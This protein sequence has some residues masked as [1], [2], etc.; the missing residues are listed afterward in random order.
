MVPRIHRCCQPDSW[1]VVPGCKLLCTNCLPSELTETREVNSESCEG[2]CFPQMYTDPA[3]LFL[4]AQ[5]VVHWEI[6]YC[7]SCYSALQI[8]LQ[9]LLASLW[10]DHLRVSTLRLLK[11]NAWRMIPRS[12]V[13]KISLLVMA[14]PLFS[15][16]SNT[17]ANTRTSYLHLFGMRRDEMPKDHAFVCHP[18]EESTRF[19]LH[20]LVT[21]E[22]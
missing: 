2:N 15:L 8:N 5:E 9:E 17:G 12:S 3:R 11:S 13:W 10:K 21:V 22:F 1:S 16:I 4:F 20:S 19:L 14:W 18:I 7:L 6:T